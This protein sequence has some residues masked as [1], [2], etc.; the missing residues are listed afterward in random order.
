MPKCICSPIVGRTP[1]GSI[2]PI[3]SLIPR[4]RTLRT[5]YVVPISRG[6]IYFAA[7][8]LKEMQ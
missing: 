1:A 4:V 6:P 2:S 8:M 5:C 3:K 7:P